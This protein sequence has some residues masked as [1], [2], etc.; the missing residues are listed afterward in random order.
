MTCKERLPQDVGKQSIIHVTTIN[1]RSRFLKSNVLLVLHILYR[2]NTC[3]EKD[4]RGALRERAEMGKISTIIRTRR[5]EW[6]ADMCSDINSA[7]G[8]S[9]SLATYVESGSTCPTLNRCCPDVN[10]YN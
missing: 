8:L 4:R 2:P 5:R 3:M 9:S 6:V 7:R 1:T 10:E